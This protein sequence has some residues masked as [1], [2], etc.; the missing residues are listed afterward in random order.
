MI[1]SAA[2]AGLHPVITKGRAP[3]DA[4]IRLAIRTATSAVVTPPAEADP[5]PS[6]PHFVGRGRYPGFD[7]ERDRMVLGSLP[8]LASRRGPG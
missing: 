3:I 2:Q 5:L 8:R 7:E 1:C 4:V 6:T